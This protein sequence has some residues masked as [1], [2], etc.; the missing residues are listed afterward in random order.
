MAG[1][2]KCHELLVQS[3]SRAK[4]RRAGSVRKRAH[5]G[6]P[7]RGWNALNASIA[8]RIL[9]VRLA[10][11]VVVHSVETINL[12]HANAIGR[13][14]CEVRLAIGVVA[15]RGTTDIVFA[16]EAILAGQLA[17]RRDAYVR[18]IAESA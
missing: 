13:C 6:A 4:F 3:L 9:A 18:R 15:A 2:R 12:R 16:G 14:T 10:V 5:L 8:G 11:A 7:R 1:R 17:S